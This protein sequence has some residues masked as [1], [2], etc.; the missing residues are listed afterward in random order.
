LC[1]G[2]P[3]TTSYVTSDNLDSD[4]DYTWT[5]VGSLPPGLS[6]QSTP[7]EAIFTGTPTTGGTFTFELQA[8]DAQGNLLWC[9]YTV[10]V[11]ELFP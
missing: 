2:Y 4:T 9:N 6:M 1:K 7:G 3:I 8:A 11:M 5:V 10:N